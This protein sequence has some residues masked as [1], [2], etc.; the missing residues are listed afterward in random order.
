ME[1]SRGGCPATFVLRIFSHSRAM[2]NNQSD[3]CGYPQIYSLIN[4][5]V[6]RRVPQIP[7]DLLPQK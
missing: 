5:M 7:G 6:R 1:W 2:M 4:N 3:G